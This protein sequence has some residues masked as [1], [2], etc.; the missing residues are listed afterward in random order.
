VQHTYARRLIIKKTSHGWPQPWPK[1]QI[2]QRSKHLMLRLL[3]AG[4]IILRYRMCIVRIIGLL[5]C[6][7]TSGN[8][9][10]IECRARSTDGMARCNEI[11]TVLAGLSGSGWISC[12]NSAHGDQHEQAY[13]KH[14]KANSCDSVLVGYHF[15]LSTG[16][17][18]AFQL[19]IKLTFNI[20]L[21]S[22]WMIC[23]EVRPTSSLPWSPISKC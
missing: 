8:A 11:R 13:Q 18:Q 12:K 16:L 9:A 17:G 23:Q 2:F 3:E 14:C 1:N 21:Y 7:N 22:T 19:L 10:R 20:T 15:F 5:T 6:I 4:H